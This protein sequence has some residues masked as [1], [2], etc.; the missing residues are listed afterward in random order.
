MLDGI[1]FYWF[2]WIGWAYCSFLMKACPQRTIYSMMLLM[3][4]I[5]QGFTIRAGNLLL[6]FSFAFLLV[7]CFMSVF[8]LRFKGVISFV[9]YSCLVALAYN[10]MLLFSLYDPVWIVVEVKWMLAGALF[11][12]SLFLMR[13]T[14]MRPYMLGAGMALGETV[15]HFI[16]KK[17]ALT[18][19]LGS[20][21]FFDVLS[22]SVALCF[23][24]EGLH[25]FSAYVYT[26]AGK[27]RVSKRASR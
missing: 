4:V 22:M 6:H 25:Q 9:F 19:E 14:G 5:L 1:F 15:Y 3:M 18:L 16:I 21:S 11:L 12:L 10:A 24:W 7:S 26:E 13:D 17:L 27:G 23:A 8:R 2:T 20:L